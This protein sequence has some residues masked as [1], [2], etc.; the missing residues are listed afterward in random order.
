MLP[1]VI[2]IKPQGNETEMQLRGY[3]RCRG[4]S[5]N[6]HTQ[7]KAQTMFCDC[8]FAIVS[9]VAFSVVAFFGFWFCENVLYIGL[10]FLSTGAEARVVTHSKENNKIK[11][12]AIVAGFVTVCVFG[13]LKYICNLN[14]LFVMKM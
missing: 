1:N 6:N 2:K 12:N 3:I 10:Q 9:M 4:T 13:F 8:A 11:C 7:K 5:S 14:Y